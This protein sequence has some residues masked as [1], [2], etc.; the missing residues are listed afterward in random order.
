[1]D[2]TASMG[3]NSNMDRTASMDKT[4]WGPCTGLIL[5][6]GTYMTYLSIYMYIFEYI[7]IYTYTEYV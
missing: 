1:M 3:K 6:I 5:I 7:Y 2:K 4:V